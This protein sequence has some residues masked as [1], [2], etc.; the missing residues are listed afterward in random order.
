MYIFNSQTELFNWIEENRPP[1]SEVS[2]KPIVNLESGYKR[3]WCFAHI[4][5]KG[6]YP[7]F[8]LYYKNILLVTPE[9]HTYFD[10]NTA[11]AKRDP[12][13]KWVFD[14]QDLLKAEYNM[15][16]HYYKPCFVPK[17]RRIDAN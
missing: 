10:D 16:D 8:K 1:I 7:K 13:W 12:Q 6:A 17:L 3:H 4:L 2:G 11:R 5:G 15:A 9:E 14:L